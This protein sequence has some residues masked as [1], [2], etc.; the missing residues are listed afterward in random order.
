MNERVALDQVVRDMH[1]A[2]SRPLNKAVGLP[3]AA[4]NDPDFLALEN[5]RLFAR[6]WVAAASMSDIP[7]PGD[8]VLVVV[9]GLPLVIL[10][11]RDGAVR[12]FHNI[13][14]HRAMTVVAERCSGLKSLRCPWHAWTYGLD[15]RLVATPNLGGIGKAE[16]EGFDKAD[17]GLKPVRVDTWLGIVFVNL[18]G[19]AKP[20]EHHTEPLRKRYA[21]FD[22]SCL[23]HGGSTERVFEANWKLAIEGGIEDYHLPWVHPQAVNGDVV[24][25][26]RTEW[27]DERY[28]GVTGKIGYDDP[29]RTP[30]T[31]TRRKTILPTFPNLPG[32]VDVNGGFICQFPNL[33]VGVF[34]DHVV[35]TI[36]TPLDAERTHARKDYLFV[37]DAAHDPAMAEARSQVIQGW[38]TIGDQDKPIVEEVHRNH[39]ARQRA[40]I[41]TVFSPYWEGA[42]QHFQKIIAGYLSR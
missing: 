27:A 38:I 10:S 5:E 18:D 42:V 7:E 40:G 3:G 19:A 24:W 13:C 2:V 16:A 17:L 28:V 11:D 34:H 30:V 23:N 1:D 25:T 21:A 8:A 32:D 37:G 29:E 33:G 41:D 35:T 4:F 15:G 6:T 14:R 20:L 36:F 22:F 39:K 31:D 26:P 9:A 12:G